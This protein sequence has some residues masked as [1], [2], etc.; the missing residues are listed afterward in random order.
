MC[1]PTDRKKDS[2]EELENIFQQAVAFEEGEGVEKD[3]DA[4]SALYRKA[5]RQGHLPSKHRLAMLLLRSAL[6]LF[7]FL[8]SNLSDTWF[9]NH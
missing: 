9:N 3:L 4:A 5:A 6:C 8:F 7:S 1:F 2:A